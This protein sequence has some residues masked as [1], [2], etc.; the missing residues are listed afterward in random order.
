MQVALHVF[1][2]I[3]AEQRLPLLTIPGVLCFVGLG[4]TPVPL[5]DREIAA[6][7]EAVRSG[8]GIEPWPFAEA[9][10]RV[11]LGK[12]P[13]GGVEGFLVEVQKQMRV[14]VNLTVLGR[15]MAVS[16]EEGWVDGQSSEAIVRA[17]RAT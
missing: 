12:G 2:K 14:V 6:I 9:G 16:V 17:A 7:Q 11:R 5:E 15:A 8:L 1:C 13:L 10:Q 3:N 4:K